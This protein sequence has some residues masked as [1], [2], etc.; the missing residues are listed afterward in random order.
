MLPKI[1]RIMRPNFTKF[2]SLLIACFYF[3]SQ[4]VLGSTTESNFWAERRRSI[5]T[6]ETSDQSPQFASLPSSLSSNVPS[7]NLL[8]QL[9]SI[10]GNLPVASKWNHAKTNGTPGLSKKF[11]DL[12]ESVPLIYGT[13]QEVYDS[14]SDRT[15]PV[16]LIQDVHLN[17]EAQTNIASVLQELIDQKQVGLVGVEGAFGA[18]DF[19][20]FRKY[21][22]K[23]ISKEVVEDL[24]NK[25]LLA[26]PSF[27]G[28]TSPTEPPEFLGIDDKQ[29]YDAN[30]EAL[31][32]ARD[33]KK[34]V[35]QQVNSLK[36]NLHEAK[37][38]IFSKELA[39]FDGLRTAYHKGDVGFGPYVKKLAAYGTDGDL[40][41]QQFLEAYGMESSL[42]FKRVENER[43]TVIEKLTKS[44]DEKEI[45]NLVAQSL[46]YRMGRIGFGSYYQGIRDLCDK[47]G[48]RLSQ[49]PNFENY[50]RYVLLSDGIK[51]DALFAAVDKME[52]DVV[53]SLVRSENESALAQLSDFVSLID[54]LLDFSLTPNE[55]EKYVKNRQTLSDISLAL[56]KLLQSPSQRTINVSLEPFETFYKEADIRSH[57]MVEKLVGHGPKEA[58]AFILGGFHS[59]QVA[60]ILRKEKISYVI[61]SP[62]LTKIDDA[63]GSSY[64]SVFAREKTPLD[65]LFAGEKLFV[66]PAHLA[67]GTNS[68]AT[69]LMNFILLTV[70][71]VL[72]GNSGDKGTQPQ[73]VA[74]EGNTYAVRYAPNE[75]E[76]AGLHI[77][78]TIVTRE[79]SLGASVASIFHGRYLASL[80]QAP[81]TIWGKIL[82]WMGRPLAG[83]PFWEWVFQTPVLAGAAFG[84]GW[85]Y[86][87]VVALIFSLA[88]GFSH[89]D[90][91]TRQKLIL[92][93]VGILFSAAMVLPLFIMGP[94]VISVILG[95][96][97]NILS[98]L[99][100]NL[101]APLIGAPL[102]SINEQDD[103][104]RNTPDFVRLPGGWRYS[105][106]ARN[107]GEHTQGWKFHVILTEKDAGRVLQVIIPILME[108]DIGHKVADGMGRLQKR[109]A[110]GGTQA[111]KGMAI[112]FSEEDAIRIGT[113]LGL[114][115]LAKSSGR[116]LYEIV[117]IYLGMRMDSALRGA[118]IGSA[119]NLD[120]DLEGRNGD[121]RFGGE[122]ST[123]RIGYRYGRF[124]DGG[125]D[126][127]LP[128]GDVAW[129]DRGRYKPEGIV[130]SLRN[131][132]DL[133]PDVDQ[134]ERNLEVDNG[135]RKSVDEI[136]T[137]S[138]GNV[139]QK[140]IEA[141][142]P[143]R[144]ISIQETT[145]GREAFKKTVGRYPN[146]K[147]LGAIVSEAAR[148][149]RNLEDV[150]NDHA[151]KLSPKASA[152]LQ[153]SV[154]VTDQQIEDY[155]NDK[156]PREDL[157]DQILDAVEGF[158]DQQ[159]ANARSPKERGELEEFYAGHRQKIKEDRQYVSNFNN[160]DWL[161]R[162]IKN[163]E[164]KLSSA[165]ER[166][167]AIIGKRIER[168]KAQ[169]ERI[170]IGKPTAVSAT[171]ETANDSTEQ[172]SNDSFRI[173]DLSEAPNMDG[174][175]EISEIDLSQ[176]PPGTLVYIDTGRYSFVLR[177]EADGKVSVW[178]AVEGLKGRSLGTFKGIGSL[179]NIM[180]SDRGGV[181]AV[182][183]S[184]IFP[185]FKFG[186]TTSVEGSRSTKV[187][188]IQVLSP[189]AAASI[190]DPLISW[191][192]N[193]S[194]GKPI[195][196][197]LTIVGASAWETYIFQNHGFASLTKHLIESGLD[198]SLSAALGIVGI[199]IAFAFAH[200]IIT[201]LAR[202]KKDGWRNAFTAKALRRDARDF[203]VRTGLSVGFT[204]PF[205]FLD[206]ITASIVTII[207]HGLYN[208]GVLTQVLPRWM[209]IASIF[210]KLFGRTPSGEG[211]ESG[212]PENGRK[213]ETDMTLD[214]GGLNRWTPNR[215]LID[216]VQNHLPSDARG[217]SVYVTFI[218]PDGSRIPLER[219]G[220]LEFQPGI[221]LEILDNGIGYD[222]DHLKL[223]LTTK[224][225]E[226]RGQF[227][228]GLK[229][230]I[231]A[232]IK[233]GIQI[234]L[235]S[236]RWE[237]EA[238]VQQK[239]VN[240]GEAN[241]I[242][243]QQVYFS[244]Q[245][246]DRK[247]RGSRTV[248]QNLPEDM[249]ASAKN[250]QNLVLPLQGRYRP[251]TTVSDT[252]EIVKV[253][254]QGQSSLYVKGLLVMTIPE[255]RNSFYNQ[256][257]FDY[258]FYGVEVGRDRDSLA[259]L[260]VIKAMEALILNGVDSDI[261]KTILTAVGV[262]YKGDEKSPLS[263]PSYD[264]IDSLNRFTRHKEIP[265]ADVWKKAFHK[266]FGSDAILCSSSRY[267]FGDTTLQALRE[268]KKLVQVPEG[269]YEILRLSGVPTDMA[270]YV[271]KRAT[272]ETSI[273]L[274]YREQAWGPLRLILD[275]VQNHLR[276]D[277]GATKI[278]IEFGVGKENVEWHDIS[279]IT[280][281]PDDQITA[282]RITDNGHGYDAELLGLLWSTKARAAEAAGKYGEG[283][284]ML[285]A[286]ALRD[287]MEIDLSSQNWLAKAVK[288]TRYVT[289]LAGNEEVAF[290]AFEI[291]HLKGRKMSGSQTTLRVLPQD[292]VKQIR[293]LPEL[294][295][296]L[297][298]NYRPVSSVKGVG[299]IKSLTPELFVQGLFVDVT[300]W[301]GIRLILGYN[302]AD[303]DL[304][305]SPDRNVVAVPKLR[306]QIGTILAQTDS[307]EAV[308][309]V[310][311]KALDN[312][313]VSYPEYQDFSAR[314]DF[315][316]QPWRK[317]VQQI[318][319][320]RKVALM[321][322]ASR[323][324]DV[325]I[326]LR[327]MGY[328]PISIN[329]EI[330]KTLHQLG[331]PYDYELMEAVYDFVDEGKLTAQE[332]KILAL[333]TAMDDLVAREL[334]IAVSPLP[335][336]VFDKARSKLGGVELATQ[337]FF[338]PGDRVIG[339]KRSMLG[340]SEDF[341]TVYVE[342]LS[343]QLSGAGDYTR[344][345]YN[346]TVKILV[347]T[348]MTKF[349][350]SGVITADQTSP[351]ASILDP[352]FAF[353]K[354]TRW[355]YPVYWLLTV[356]GASIWETY[357]FQ[358]HGFASLTKYLVESGVDS[359]LSAALGV[360]GIGIAFAFAH[361][362]ITW[363]VRVKKLG[364]RN[365]FSAEALQ[366]DA[367]DFGIR[368]GLSIGFTLPFLF[369][370]PITASIVAIIAHSLYNAA[371]LAGFLP[372]G[373]P[374]ASIF[375]KLKALLGGATPEDS[376]QDSGKGSSVGALRTRFERALV[377]QDVPEIQRIIAD[378][379]RLARPSDAVEILLQISQLNLVPVIT[380]AVR[381]LDRVIRDHP[382]ARTG[383]VERTLARIASS[384]ESFGYGADAQFVLSVA[385]PPTDN[386]PAAR[387]EERRS[388]TR[389][390]SPGRENNGI[391]Q[392]RNY[393]DWLR[394][395]RAAYSLE[396]GGQEAAQQVG[397]GRDFAELYDR[398][399][400]EVKQQLR[401]SGRI[402]IE[403]V[404]ALAE[405]VLRDAEA[406]KPAQS[407]SPAREFDRGTQNE[408]GEAAPS[409]DASASQERIGQ[410]QGRRD[411]TR[412]ANPADQSAPGDQ[413]IIAEEFSR[414]RTV[415]ATPAAEAKL[416][417]DFLSAYGDFVV[418][419]SR[420]N[421]NGARSALV[422]RARAVDPALART[423][424]NLARVTQSD[425]W[426]NGEAVLRE[427]KAINEFLIGK[428]YYL[429]ANVISDGRKALYIS[430]YY[431]IVEARLYP[432]NGSKVAAIHL[433]RLDKLNIDEARLGHSGGDGL[434]VVMRDKIRMNVLNTVLP[435][436]AEALDASWDVDLPPSLVTSASRLIE[437]DLLQMLTPSEMTRARSLAALLGQRARLMRRL[438]TLLKPYRAGIYS[439]SLDLL[440]NAETLSAVQQWASQ[441]GQENLAREITRI[442][443]EIAS[444]RG[445]F[446]PI[447]DK[448]IAASARS[449][450][451]HELTHEFDG[452]RSRV[453]PVAYSNQLAL[454]P[455]FG[456]DL[457]QLMQHVIRPV[458]RDE[459]E[460]AAT[461]LRGLGGQL[462]GTRSV[463]NVQQIE[464]L[465]ASIRD[466]PAEE[467]GV[468]QTRSHEREFG[469]L[470]VTATDVQKARSL[471]S[472]F[473]PL[474]NWLRNYS[475][476]QPIYWL[477]T[478]VG[479]S[480]WETYI[481]Q[482]QGFAA[483]NEFLVSSG[484]DSSLSAALGMA[485]IGVVFAFAHTIIT[486]L[487][488][489][490]KL[491]WRDAFSAEALRGDAKDF[492][493]RTGLSIGFTIPFLFLDPITAS[494]VTI[495]L[496]GL[497][498]SGVLTEILPRWMPIASVLSP[499]K[500]QRAR[501]PAKRET[502][503]AERTPADEIASKLIS[504]ITTSRED[505]TALATA[506]FN[507]VDA[508]KAFGEDFSRASAGK[509]A[510]WRDV[511]KSLN[512]ELARLAEL[513][514]FNSTETRARLADL[515]FIMRFVLTDKEYRGFIGSLRDI[516]IRNKNTE[517]RGFVSWVSNLSQVRQLIGAL[518][519][520]DRQV[521]GVDRENNQLIEQLA[522][523]HG[524]SA[525]ELKAKGRL[526]IIGGK[527]E[528]VLGDKSINAAGFVQIAKES[529][530]F[531]DGVALNLLILDKTN[532][533]IGFFR[534]SAVE[535][536]FLKRAAYI[537]FVN[538]ALQAVE[539]DA[540]L[541]P[542][543][544]V[545]RA[546]LIQA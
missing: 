121:K 543:W 503:A 176:L 425:L 544:N 481:F 358:N 89:R 55:W 187:Q 530:L 285:A 84:I 538:E 7:K 179:K 162:Q 77:G 375:D 326:H 76:A 8:K 488:R 20:P 33:Q 94:S 417:E 330:G 268:K 144:F 276:E 381:E 319:G 370:D 105:P 404:I 68:R 450:E 492:G 546:R 346:F 401:S 2:L 301:Q 62:K 384:L 292:M 9:P 164:A 460:A 491:G 79:K 65:R 230:A 344:E 445:D 256:A 378:A 371:V 39:T 85:P 367:R 329:S 351:K 32:S 102:A 453:E 155:F 235:A 201:W 362:I 499:E 49:T 467:R 438:N 41:I 81:A 345:L 469:P 426:S 196:W 471:A 416:I 458:G 505:R 139:G 272:I 206:P 215:I 30:L 220:D 59:P 100:Y 238:K 34:E 83:A 195:Y 318:F 324:P 541:L 312:G 140:P 240:P 208:S 494:I 413:S 190:I 71:S 294:V 257:L 51:A 309:T 254:P 135:L 296:Q 463:I 483:L 192:R 468:V 56:S 339:I 188:R 298:P 495:I 457:V 163:D 313:S 98:H 216:L 340:S 323:N 104:I 295:L 28:I 406:S 40:I 69:N 331:L 146:V 447:V 267:S 27:V 31:Y 13:I 172:S 126:I 521:I 514:D 507:L 307:V 410:P 24:L 394:E 203:G 283:L 199:G 524:F 391:P 311:N 58:S 229:I 427:A 64:L 545:L 23:E 224:H 80:T 484:L 273:S 374:I 259:R 379:G 3:A 239:V 214:Y 194:W 461:V 73:E 428:G 106:N 474:I 328:E 181:F 75:A 306:E 115:K 286:A 395:G 385:K 300:T 189:V 231:A 314:D 526:E 113:K 478:I 502:G 443:Q 522:K 110:A 150:A 111:G 124:D 66:Y 333:R 402:S 131:V 479:A 354:N 45:S 393:L 221:T 532:L 380:A 408:A 321:T 217:S 219:S 246:A 302:L 279:E 437:Q 421:G 433:E 218:L 15:S 325:L 540:S 525:S 315:R 248:L 269:L 411:E 291:T 490:K 475:W 202:V 363:L 225:G 233:R 170:S 210:D 10:S 117:A 136:A 422:A 480:A 520:K 373:A 116:D 197:L 47:K 130:Q 430:T 277:S 455:T 288:K 22:N 86:L 142:V 529:T 42:D 365:A 4:V 352:I 122:T 101:I 168:Y 347:R 512:S 253:S 397:F 464:R 252:G 145:A 388:P 92:A 266:A 476:G 278:Q 511:A 16:V 129:D 392:F 241:E 383:Q 423:A 304:I 21:P 237:A 293:R 183:D 282:F 263:T 265:H 359:S 305:V 405:K 226:E 11:Q 489:V 451:I 420:G 87:I 465:F 149:G 180:A 303:K 517:T 531:S 107:Y 516:P 63:S 211:S 204:I 372:K 409:R 429:Y 357:V 509:S 349:T 407:A 436:L 37:V 112:Y 287:G 290:L 444:E 54:K 368:T 138:S 26:A 158:I 159:I 518:G 128:N 485:G 343:H 132:K 403:Q 234:A 48:I 334:G 186:E 310:I 134:S 173:V 535:L 487:V 504:L 147:E 119:E 456:I 472:I 412:V 366:G 99:V 152:P 120:W 212:E 342:E 332:R 274:A 528:I 251:L 243:T 151:N 25:N 19:R 542:D 462:L 177:V 123:G 418:A 533:P 245:D 43:R 133:F 236:R 452:D 501:R 213:L 93:G 95:F 46:A 369:L 222:V 91:T 320:G 114:D 356:V 439:H 281:F 5:S 38:K 377:L 161:D 515:M 338:H 141:N 205:L 50:I 500:R 227:G 361:T 178:T 441:I 29:H 348:A 271:E 185:I 109:I 448:V 508:E 317:A 435:G 400:Q 536:S 228:E 387:Q 247:L 67:V 527:V 261:A 510:Q 482:N 174:A 513:R 90:K 125:Y 17:T 52:Q 223:F 432:K 70:L 61:V 118:E 289:T 434:A 327:H 442:N 446:D 470:L 18:F 262:M 97:A 424:E 477:L 184:A 88:F 6:Q 108:L 284:K 167:R 166:M 72:P 360:A 242:R 137:K 96:P 523:E 386:R 415:N 308:V 414:V 182:G 260:D 207:L 143:P 160:P 12:I 1:I 14:R 127:N 200:T 60:Q 376:P 316:P 148:S 36:Q 335:I 264:D 519:A 337:G 353:L 249:F 44:L 539:V 232:A 454:S 57:K 498:N 534:L 497:Y 53:S 355:G 250:L 396:M 209:P 486:W 165:N 389:A 459:N 153:S 496:H 82:A 449:V 350:E 466:L 74:Y 157:T 473:D 280:K 341:L 299:E 258:N 255:R 169:R 398:L 431:R 493:I 390:E 322:R 275:A 537:Y 297:N 270:L 193:Y 244:V 336:K 419:L 35:S 156:T 399:S 175:V 191:L 440:I 382:D 506:I 103:I 78:P 171:E 198:A 364:W 154:A